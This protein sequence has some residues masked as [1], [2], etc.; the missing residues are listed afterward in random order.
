MKTE[1]IIFIVVLLGNGAV[2]LW[3]K[4]K[5]QAAS[6]PEAAPRPTA[7]PRPAPRP[8]LKPAG[9]AASPRRQPQQ[10]TP[11]PIQPAREPVPALPERERPAAVVVA[12]AVQVAEDR[13]PAL[14]T[15]ARPSQQLPAAK[16]APRNGRG[17]GNLRQWVVGAEILGAPRWRAPLH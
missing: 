8:R 17:L 5:E 6:R 3:K 9:S 13:V 1:L 2:A 12:A 14:H 16:A 15:A 10:P 7:S 4:Y 11:Q